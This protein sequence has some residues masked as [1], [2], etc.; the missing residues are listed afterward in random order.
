M[1]IIELPIQSDTGRYAEEL[2]KKVREEDILRWYIAKIE[3][4]TAVLEVVR[5]VRRKN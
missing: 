1:E 3:D 5:E 4:G 2:K